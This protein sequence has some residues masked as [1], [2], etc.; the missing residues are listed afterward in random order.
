[1]KPQVGDEVEVHY[2]CTVKATGAQFDSSRDRGE[3]FKFEVG[4]SAVIE[5]WDL[6]V[7]TMFKGETAK[8]TIAPECAYGEEGKGDDVPPD[9]EVIVE[10]ELVNY[11]RREDLFGDG[12][13]IKTEVVAGPGQVEPRKNEE[14]LMSLK[15]SVGSEVLRA[16]R[17]T[18]YQMG[19]GTLGR[20]SQAID[21][22]LG[23]MHRG[24]E[25]T[26]MCTTQYGCA[27]SDGVSALEQPTKVTLILEQLHEVLD[28]TIGDDSETGVMKK[29]L[30][31]GEGK[32]KPNDLATVTLRVESVM[33]NAEKL[34]EADLPRELEFTLG[35]GEVCDALEG[36]CLHMRLN[37]VGLVRCEKSDW[38]VGGLLELPEPL[39]S[40][41]LIQCTLV[42]F[43]LAVDKFD[44]EDRERVDRCHERKEVAGRLFKQG[45]IRLAAY[46]YGLITSFFSQAEL[47]RDPQ[48][49]EAG[50]ELRR[51]ARLNKAMCALKMKNWKAVIS[52]CDLV[53]AED[54]CSAKAL[55]RRATAS[56]EMKDYDTAIDDFTRVLELE[57]S[58]ADGRKL[59]QQAK[60][61]KKD[62]D[63]RQLP[64]FSRMCDAFGDMPERTDRRDD[65]I[66]AMPDH[67]RLGFT[68]PAA[69]SSA[70]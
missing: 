62:G 20:L 26:L 53:L 17:H 60:R 33:A 6:G 64:M 46:H 69:P 8:F 51:L 22:A 43:S 35:N 41:V 11:P 32:E 36:A 14:V 4:S 3:T 59:L 39:D 70:A 56:L 2:V 10:V 16:A 7:R 12:G 34:I 61:L 19:S 63:K 18:V 66:V 25:A 1:M 65:D 55:F 24:D 58:S 31:E 29:R 21:K 30:Q 15:V 50:K 9:S 68:T 27:G 67:L 54:P 37:E 23:T 28:V 42:K 44:M 45:R 57:P 13:A 48:D 49:Q 52:L 38:C 40:P 5:G 47:F